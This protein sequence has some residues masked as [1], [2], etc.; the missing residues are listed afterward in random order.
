METKVSKKLRWLLPYL[1]I[2]KPLMPEGKSIS[3]LSAWSINNKRMGKTC[4]ACIYTE[5]WIT[6]RIYMHTQ[7][8]PR[9]SKVLPNSKIDML[10]NLAHELAHT[11]DMNH[12]PE[13]KQL[14]N[15]LLNLFM[16]HLKSTGYIDEET[17]LNEMICG[18]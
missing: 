8:H 13:H 3:R 16:M 12:S 9:N 4:L 6:Y 2:A 15:N 18:T 11:L 14:E 5:D 17:E 7:R 1:D 10:S